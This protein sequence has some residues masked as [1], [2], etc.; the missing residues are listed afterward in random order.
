MFLLTLFLLV[1][2]LLWQSIIYTRQL[3]YTT[4]VGEYAS[5]GIPIVQHVHTNHSV[6]VAE[7]NSSIQNRNS[8]AG[9]VSHNESTHKP[10]NVSVIGSDLPRPHPHAGARFVNGSWG[11]VADVYNVRNRVVQT[12]AATLPGINDVANPFSPHLHVPPSYLILRNEELNKVCKAKPGK[13]SEK[14]PG[15]KLLTE[16]VT[17]NFDREVESQEENSRILCAIFTHD[18]KKL[19]IQAAG[20]TWGWKCDGFFAAS[21]KTNDEIG[22]IDLAHEG[23][24]EYMNMWQKTRSILA[25][26]YDNY[27]D[28]FEFFFLSGDDTHL[29][30]ENLRQL[31]RSMQT[32][33]HEFPLYLGFLAP[34]R[35]GYYVGG[36]GGYVLNRLA[37]KAFVE[38]SLP[39]CLAHTRIPAEDR[40][41]A[42]CLLRLGIQANSSV[43]ELGEQI[44]HGMDPNAVATYDGLGD[45]P[46][47]MSVY[48]SWGDLWGFKAGFNVTSSHSASFH[49]LK[50]PQKLKRHHAILY[51]SCPLGTSL[52]DY[53]NITTEK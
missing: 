45:R 17:V 26:M 28:D 23:P 32:K 50:T 4:D 2:T 24:E 9:F 38:Q 14:M 41:L 53:F 7:A 49:W 6:V 5:H 40:M 22:A 51:R 43:D 35:Y 46:W 33:G 11:Y 1:A 16:K 10:V 3:K 42:N 30:V 36:G 39:S 31:L 52:G 19:T 15:W 29:I 44:F 12:Y 37:L 18:G 25:Y 27:L 34:F 48:K 13:G 8:L 21:T 20:E 47:F